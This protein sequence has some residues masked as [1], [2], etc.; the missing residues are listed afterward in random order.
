MKRY[1]RLLALLTGALVLLPGV[2]SAYVFELELSGSRYVER[3]REALKKGN[4][5]VAIK[6][7]EMGI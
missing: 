1:L 5:K 3:G 4:I 6:Q 2:A 7:Y